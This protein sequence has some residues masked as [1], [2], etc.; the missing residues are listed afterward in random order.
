[1]YS[2]HYKA[3]RSLVNIVDNIPFGDALEE[4]RT[5]IYLE[6]I[7]RQAELFQIE[8]S[9]IT[10]PDGVFPKEITSFAYNKNKRSIQTIIDKYYNRSQ[11]G[12]KYIRNATAVDINDAQ[13]L[14]HSLVFLRGNVIWAEFGFNIGCEFGG[15]HPAIIL[16][17]LGEALIVAP[18]TSGTLTN[19]KPSEVIIDMVYNLPKR[20]RYTNITRITPISIYR[21]DLFSPVGSIRSS[22][23][24][25]IFTAMKNDW[26]L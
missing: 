22:K 9:P 23:M 7:S 6:W 8:K 21:V 10:I 25:E 16:K 11:D 1:M 5:G 15:K 18:L 19:P 13:D 2:K 14:L 20:D 3:N 12:N 24:K 17:N 4:K 26:N